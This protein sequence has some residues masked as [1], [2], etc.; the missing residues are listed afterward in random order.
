MNCPMVNAV[1]SSPR[2]QETPTMETEHRPN[3]ILIL[4]DDMGFAD[5]GLMGSEVRTPHIDAMARHGAV[6]TSMY[7]CA[8]CAAQRGLRCLPGCTRTRPASA[9]W[10]P[11]W[12]APPT[13]V[14]CAATRPPLPSGCATTVTGP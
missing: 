6:L 8:R 4:A 14:T 7:N 9:T 3:V 12:E 1:D 10:A 5:L 2:K 11:T 13:R